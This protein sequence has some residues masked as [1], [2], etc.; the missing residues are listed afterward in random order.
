MSQSGQG[1]NTSEHSLTGVIKILSTHG[2][3]VFL[4]V[5][6]AMF[7]YPDSFKE[8]G[9]WIAKIEE[10]R[11]SINPEDKPLTVS[12][13]ESILDYVTDLYFLNVQSEVPFNTYSYST[14]SGGI[15]GGSIFFGGSGAMYNNGMNRPKN[16]VDLNG[17]G[18]H[19]TIDLDNKENDI[20]RVVH[21]MLEEARPSAKE[22]V[23]TH[24]EPLLNRGFDNALKSSSRLRLFNFGD[25]T[26]YE[27]WT[28]IVTKNE[29]TFKTELLQSLEDAQ[30][31][32]QYG[33]LNQSLRAQLKIS[34]S[35]L[36]VEEYMRP[37]QVLNK[38]RKKMKNEW[39][40]K[41]K[42]SELTGKSQ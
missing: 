1:S 31:S 7:L 35:R 42:G 5:Y 18:F 41:I 21:T 30:V 9:A 13:T 40:L 33:S 11:R 8:R 34:D 36:K 26:L 12:Q 15:V 14:P 39:L 20:Q 28:D 16:A 29:Q 10:L 23:I 17:L 37:N 32:L 19:F 2:L 25:A 4:V 24:Y 38:Y 27:L 22:T 6:Y 3:A